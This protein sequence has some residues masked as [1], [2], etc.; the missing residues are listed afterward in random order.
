MSG[1]LD[2]SMPRACPVG[3]RCRCG[4]SDGSA[5]EKSEEKDGL[6]GSWGL[7]YGMGCRMVW[8]GFSI[9]C[10]MCCYIYLIILCLIERFAESGGYEREFVSSATLHMLWR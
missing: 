10:Q 7:V 1:R 6:H 4:C 9:L 2:A 5:S 8:Y 3:G